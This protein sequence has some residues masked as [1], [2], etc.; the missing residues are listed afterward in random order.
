MKKIIDQFL[1]KK[2]FASCYRVMSNIAALT[3][4]DI[5]VTLKT[6]THIGIKKQLEQPDRKR[7]AIHR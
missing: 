3:Y 6:I 1:L 7:K 4:N 5:L 2:L